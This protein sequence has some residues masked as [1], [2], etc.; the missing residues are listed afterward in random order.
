ML[1]GC[2]SAQQGAVVVIVTATP[3]P[4]TATPTATAT[5][6]A[7]DTPLPTDTPTVT[8]MP[9]ATHTA[10]PTH[11]PG[12]TYTPRPTY[13]PTNT[14]TPEP[15]TEYRWMSSR[16]QSMTGIQRSAFLDTYV[17]KLVRIV[18]SVY[19]VFS[20]GDIMFTVN[21]GSGFLRKV[22]SDISMKLHIGD[23]ITFVARIASARA[24]GDYVDL[25][26]YELQGDVT[27]TR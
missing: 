6:E 20:D 22:P 18:G 15:I 25:E 17:G 12:P 4:A 19:E 26:M 27:V 24:Y 3:E 14:P 9:T 7:T 13:T 2:G 10:L 1:A 16:M 21:D 8:A 11:T 23:R 5:P